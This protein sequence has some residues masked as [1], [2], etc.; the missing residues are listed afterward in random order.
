MSFLLA[1]MPPLRKAGRTLL[2]CVVGFGAATIVFGLSRSFPLSLAMLFLTGVFDSVSVI[3][4]HT[5]V[6]LL[7][8]DDMRGVL[9]AINSLFIGAS[10]ELGAFESGAVAHLFARRL[11]LGIAL[12]A[13]LS[14]VVGGIGTILVV[15]ITAL[16]WPPLRRY[17]QLGEPGAPAIALPVAMPEPNA[18]VIA[19]ERG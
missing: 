6:Q 10:N 16:L 8:P 4:R 9:A 1:H 19:D 13:T 7:T 14:V 11:D 5:L 12:G 17:G 18:K 15:I 2:W 3:V